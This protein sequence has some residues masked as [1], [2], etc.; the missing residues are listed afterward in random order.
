MILNSDKNMEETLRILYSD[1]VIIGA[2]FSGIN[3]ACQLQRKLGFTEYVI[4]DRAP[5]LG[6]AWSANKCKHCYHCHSIAAENT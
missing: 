4:Y 5:D 3:L 1:V 2:G 6:G